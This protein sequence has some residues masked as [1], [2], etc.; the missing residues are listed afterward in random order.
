MSKEH[1][2]KISLALTG[3]KL[4]EETKK[5]MSISHQKNNYYQKG[6]KGEKNYRWKGDNACYRAKHSLVQRTKGKAI[7]C[8]ECGED[9][10]RI[11]WANIDHKYSRNL[12]DYI[13][14]CAKCHVEYDKINGLRKKY[15]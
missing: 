13:A 6:I 15:E 14:L 12:E 11:H 9:K 5:K 1:R 2:K 7:K 8:S 3:R 10:K 4:S